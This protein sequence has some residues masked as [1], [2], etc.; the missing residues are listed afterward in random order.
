MSSAQ[1]QQLDN[2]REEDKTSGSDPVARMLL[3]QSDDCAINSA[4]AALEGGGRGKEGPPSTPAVGG[5]ADVG[6]DV[7]VS[8]PHAFE[9]AG[10]YGGGGA[11]ASVLRST[12]NGS[13]FDAP[14]TAGLF[15]LGSRGAGF[16]D[17]STVPRTRLFKPVA[18]RVP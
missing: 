10:A 6:V 14:R 8:S 13:D 1:C 4:A 11:A 2:T 7:G 16:G 12:A 15:S 5:V 9:V 18:F 3:R 17:A